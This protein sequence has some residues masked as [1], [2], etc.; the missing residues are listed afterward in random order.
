MSGVGHRGARG[1]FAF[2]YVRVFL[3]VLAV[4]AV[5]SA[6]AAAGIG[7][8]SWTSIGPH[9]YYGGRVQS[10][11]IHPADS[12]RM[13]AGAAGGGI[14][15]TTD[16][17]A[18]WT[19]YSDTLPSLAITSIVIAP[20][21]NSIM[22]AGS[23]DERNGVVGAGIYKSTNGGATW[24]QLP[25]TIPPSATTGTWRF[26]R[27]LAI[28]PGNDNILLAATGETLY[29]STDGGA[30]WQAKGGSVSDVAF[31]PLDGNR[32]VATGMYSSD[33]GATWTTLARKPDTAVYAW[34]L[35]FG[36]VVYESAGLLPPADAPNEERYSGTISRS[37]D[38][39][40]TWTTLADIK[41]LMPY[42]WHGNAIWVDPVDR[43]LILAGGEGLW[44]ST[45]GGVSWAQITHG[46]GLPQTGWT[47]MQAIVTAPGYN[48]STNRAVFVASGG[49]VFKLT[50]TG[51]APISPTYWTNLNN[52]LATVQF[53]SGT[54]HTGANGG[55]L[56]GTAATGTI[57]MVAGT[58]GWSI[59]DVGPHGGYAA[60]DPA[61]G[62]IL[63]GSRQLSSIF[64]RNAG[65]ALP[66]QI[67]HASP[68]A[69]EDAFKEGNWAAPML[70]DP[71]NSNV[72]YVGA[73]SLWRTW[74]AKSMYTNWAPIFQRPETI[75]AH[76]YISHLDV[77]PG[78][79]AVIWVVKANG[80][81]FRT[82]N[83]TA[84][85]PTW[86]QVGFSG[87]TWPAFDVGTVL[88]D[89]DDHHTAYVGGK[90]GVWR[91]VDAGASWKRINAS[92]LPAIWSIQRHPSHPGYLYL[93]T[94][95]GIFAS[96]NGGAS[97]SAAN[98]LPVNIRVTQLFW[99]NASTLVAAT[100]GRGMY[101]ATVNVPANVLALSRAGSGTGSISSSP[102]GINCGSTCSAAYGTGTV[103][104]LTATAQAGSTFSGWG[105][106]CS[107]AGLSPTCTVTMNGA[108]S[109]SATFNLGYT[110]SVSV[111]GSGAV[112]SNPA[113]INCGSACSAGF[114]T[115][116]SVT[117]TATPSTGS[118]FLGWT[119]AC[120]GTAACPLSMTAGKTVQAQFAPGS[121]STLSVT[122]SGS[123]SGT[124]T[125][126][127]AGITCGAQCS[128]GYAYGTSVT[129]TA[130]PGSGSHFAGWSGGCS[131][132][133]T[134]CTVSMIQARSVTATFNQ[135]T[136]Y[137][138]TVFKS[139]TGSGPV[140]SN[141]GGIVC[142][143][144]CSAGYAQGTIV[145]LTATPN[146]NSTFSGWSGAC[147]GTAST[148]VVTMDAVK[149]V[150]ATFN[151][152]GYALTVTK[153]GTGS[154]PVVSSPSGIAC[155]SSCSASF[156]N[157]AN[158]TLTA[159]P[160]SGSVFAGWS[161]ACTGTATCVVSMSAA[162]QVTA[163]FNRAG[164]LA[165][166]TKAG[167]GSG[168]VVSSP[169]GLVCGSAC[170]ANFAP[171]TLL[172]LTATAN[173]GSVFTG[174]SGGGCG[175]T[176]P[177]CMT[178]VYSNSSVTAVFEPVRT[179][180][181]QFSGGGTGAVSSN[182][183]GLQCSSN[184][185]AGFGLGSTVSLTAQP[186]AESRFMGW[187]GACSGTGSCDITMSSSRTVTAVFEP[188]PLAEAL[189]TTGLTWTTS[190]SGGS[191]Y[192]RSQTAVSSDG[193]DAAQAGPM[194]PPAIVT[195]STT[196]T[197]P[198]TIQFQW[199]IAG[200][201][202]NDRLTFLIDGVQR[203]ELT[204]DSG[205]QSATF[206]LDAGT[207]TLDWRFSNFGTWTFDRAWV[208]QVR[209][210]TLFGSAV[211][212]GKR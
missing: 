209:I 200:E 147:T 71:N 163:T 63:Y 181:V 85:Q 18:S 93:G 49:G 1:I 142:G 14:W 114:A 115:G 191:N 175:T 167:S 178:Y 65:E 98:E 40:A 87:T 161:G 100:F 130:T 74:N 19:P 173:P 141:P 171:G 169:A 8:A 170:S 212:G 30:T 91:T 90:G 5:K 11:A 207:H 26:V 155:G 154:G 12:K 106:A 126:V 23:G 184:C 86:I 24:T 48:G 192:W 83:G 44:R 121:N 179:L 9:T 196:V 95:K 13:W 69:L 107:G 101:S 176:S 127:P 82:D 117:L 118:V 105:G 109:A 47:G 84:E 123:G 72:L 104:T 190:S 88:I 187:S 20:V 159:T 52:G 94:E 202:L 77:A 211:K 189:D 112:T 157:G 210:T 134:T 153:A 146:T 39:G 148:C 50:D 80:D 150:T 37:T 3:G 17:G 129:L 143:S 132:S 124:V 208:D 16:G 60:I 197:G 36:S 2:S 113:G 195:L 66:L 7:P 64:R 28:H 158:V 160:N 22:Y 149:S 75:K 62:S 61:D 198:G 185:S 182:P 99:T 152:K 119:G 139:G 180:G 51:A 70:L 201:P 138:L 193:I 38:G 6:I 43:N 32:V 135:G 151:M 174:W 45:N 194:L 67:H 29:R 172:T 145:T 78:N 42:A 137:G 199:R 76:G 206:D 81:V 122:R 103:V 21:N 31:H 58:T 41:H 33:G 35:E 68:N 46:G 79:S 102:A 162:R 116:A 73:S 136:Q 92:P 27:K 34:S 131:G 203:S 97:W 166:I 15:K 204:G 57:G 165:T 10:I 177:V 120:S 140:T 168:S 4:A 205:W 133:A 144:T 25:S 110:L 156:T 53:R 164:Y 56:G 108:R 96:D 55:I 125:S 111:T 59:V 188:F 128:S 183:A 89:R 54:G 186:A